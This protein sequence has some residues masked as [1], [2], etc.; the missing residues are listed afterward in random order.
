[1]R[2]IVLI[3]LLCTPAAAADISRSRTIHSDYSIMRINARMA[4]GAF[5]SDGVHRL[6]DVRVTGVRLSDRPLL[7]LRRIFWYLTDDP[8]GADTSVSWRYTVRTRGYVVSRHTWIADERVVLTTTLH[9]PLGPQR[10]LRWA[11]LVVDAREH[12]GGTRI[13]LVARASVFA[14][15]CPHRE[16][17]RFRCVRRIADR[18]IAAELDKGLARLERTGRSL[19]DAGAIRK[20]VAGLMR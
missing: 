16:D 1:M 4:L 2:S 18:R 19:S 10:R 15:I 7:G 14:G 17:S 13:R 3:A 12:S 20:V 11:V 8:R 5:T 9:G 6:G